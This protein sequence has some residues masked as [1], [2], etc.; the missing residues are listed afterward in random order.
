MLL[1]HLHSIIARACCRV[2]WTISTSKSTAA[3]PLCPADCSG[4]GICTNP[5]QYPSRYLQ[6]D[7]FC[8]CNAGYSGPYCQGPQQAL[9]LSDKFNADNVVLQPGAWT[10]YQVSFSASLYNS[11]TYNSYLSASWS[12]AGNPD[13]GASGV[14]ISVTQV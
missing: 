8:I 5:T 9:Q 4:R 10:Y 2:R 11:F 14:A 12:L 3:A 13:Q 6:P 7:Y 1:C